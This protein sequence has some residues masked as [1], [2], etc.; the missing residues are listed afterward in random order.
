MLT[1]LFSSSARVKLLGL[2]MFNPAQSFYLRQLARALR[3]P[4]RAIQ[5]ETDRL[6]KIGLL[7]K[8]ADGNRVYFR[9]E[10]GH[11]LYPEIKRLFLKAFGAWALWGDAFRRSLDIRLAFIYG[12][13]AADEETPESDIDLFV[14]GEISARRLKA[15][16][17]EFRVSTRR[18]LNVYVTSL[19]DLRAA[20]LQRDGF[21]RKVMMS[22]KVFIVGDEHDLRQIDR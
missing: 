15:A 1:S 13:F 18:N 19:A 11:F 6:V 17:A 12:S 8:A 20:I 3:L 21:I 7:K 10:A 9:V 16:F 4:V 2:L 22:P 5:R 14:V